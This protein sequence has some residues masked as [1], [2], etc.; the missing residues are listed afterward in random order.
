M[1]QRHHPHLNGIMTLMCCLALIPGCTRDTADF[2]AA[3]P[4]KHKAPLPVKPEGKPF[5]LTDGS[6]PLRPFPSPDYTAIEAVGKPEVMFQ[7]SHEKDIID[8]KITPDSRLIVSASR[9]RTVKIWTIDGVLL[10]TIPF[11]DTD[12]SC[13]AISTD[14]GRFAVGARQGIFEL[15]IDGRMLR[16]LK[17]E[18]NVFPH[19]YRPWIV[20]GPDG[21]ILT[22]TGSRTV[23]IRDAN[24]NVRKTV[25]AAGTLPSSPGDVK[26]IAVSPDGKYFVTCGD[27][28]K[29]ADGWEAYAQMFDMNGNLIADLDTSRPPKQGETGKVRTSGTRPDMAEISPDG[30]LIALL[31]SQNLRL[32]TRDG[33]VVRAMTTKPGNLH[34]FMF[35][36]DGKAVIIN[37]FWEFHKYNID[38]SYG[39]IL[40]MRIKDDPGRGGA[41]WAAISNNGR[42]LVTGHQ[43]DKNLGGGIRIWDRQGRLRKDLRPMAIEAKRLAFSP[44]GK[45]LYLEVERGRQ[46]VVWDMGGRYLETV[47]ESVRFTREGREL[48]F[49]EGS[50]QRFHLKVNGRETEFKERHYAPLPD[51]TLIDWNGRVWESDGSPKRQIAAM[52]PTWELAAE[53]SMRYFVT[54]PGRGKEIK[55]HDPEGRHVATV[56]TERARIEPGAMAAHRDMVAVGHEDGTVSL[57]R[58]DEKQFRL[59]VDEA[60]LSPHRRRRVPKIGNKIAETKPH[61]LAVYGIAF[62]PDG[63]YLA[64]CSADRTVH[65]MNLEKKNAVTLVALSGGEWYAFDEGGRFECSDG[66][67]D[68]IMFVKGLTAYDARQ[69]WDALYEPGLITAFFRGMRAAPAN[70]AKAMNSAPEVS[71]ALGQRAVG[72]ETVTVTVCARARENGVGRIFVL[73]NGRSIDEAARGMKVES[74]GNCKSFTLALEP[75]ENRITG[76]AY[77]AGNTVF[78]TSGERMAA[79]AAP[80]I[81]RPDMHILAVGVSDY[82]DVNIRLGYPADDARSVSAAFARSGA[83]LYGRINAT[84]L[85]DAAATRERVRAELAGITARARRNDIVVIFFA[86]H[87]DTEGETY[88]YLPYEADLT[89]LKKSAVSIDE[90]SAFAR[91]LPAGKVMLLFDTCR[92][93]AATAALQKI[94][95]SRGLDERKIIAR[96][97]RE[98]GIAVFSA[99]SASQEA[100]EIRELGHGIFTH[101]LVSALDGPP[102]AVSEGGVITVS[103]LL[104][105]VNRTTRETALKYLKIEQTPIVYIFGEDFG[106][107]RVK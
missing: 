84:V 50:F 62:S 64:S 43:G 67:R 87:G 16:V 99:A 86:G 33:D 78:G 7:R 47:P 56:E 14:G 3:P 71:V 104:G 40:K 58:I 34:N 11:P 75:G 81:E 102:D 92:S 105:R 51:G 30:S 42:H 27:G 55:L 73:H 12:I 18:D 23:L 90:L 45:K 28:I 35:T 44:D 49:Y 54:V 38:G 93:G 76:A 103:R 15:S 77:D 85:T 63:K 80:A 29:S 36:P 24:W 4:G 31:G 95:L 107:G 41:Q 70:M 57:Y 59:D 37:F 26:H 48:R 25:K 66:A 52:N 101:C 39:G 97:A 17:G 53:P 8:I 100:F 82:R 88:Y 98:H 69:M 74:R 32:V 68:Q 22:T 94:A 91:S 2:Y 79:Y 21:S 46:T 83:T 9:D 20:Y 60:T 13:L 1:K 5:T 106:I 96:I 61:L 89:D 6:G 19:H 72:D 10:K 65:V